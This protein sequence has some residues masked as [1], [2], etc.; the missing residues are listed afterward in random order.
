V[1]TKYD[2][3]TVVDVVTVDPTRTYLFPRFCASQGF[4]TSNAAQAKEKSYCNQHPTDQLFPLT[5]ELF[6]CLHKHVD[7]F[8]HNFANAIWSLKGTRGLHLST[9]VIFLRKKV[10]ITLQKMQMSSILSWAIVVD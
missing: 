3:H 4:V 6:G 2:I 9:L 10:L 1:L 8:L 5:I 7:A